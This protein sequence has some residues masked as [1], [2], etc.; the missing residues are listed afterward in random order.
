[1]LAPAGGNGRGHKCVQVSHLGSLNPEKSLLLLGQEPIPCNA[2]QNTVQL[3]LQ[4]TVLRICLSESLLMA[5]AGFGWAIMCWRLDLA[6]A[7]LEDTGGLPIKSICKAQPASKMQCEAGAEKPP[8]D[9]VAG[10]EVNFHSSWLRS[11][12][13]SEIVLW[14]EE[15]LVMLLTAQPDTLYPT[16][17]TAWACWVNALR[18]K[19][20]IVKHPS[21]VHRAVVVGLPLQGQSRVPRLSNSLPVS[22]PHQGTSELGCFQTPVKLARIKAAVCLGLVSFS[23]IC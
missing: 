15:V 20:S 4:S 7:F 6:I 8:Q 18:D 11:T 2:Q 9:Q 10:N 5:S 13:S 14:H 17:G 22:L 21:S 16:K 23:Q 12:C 1:M 3:T 19:S